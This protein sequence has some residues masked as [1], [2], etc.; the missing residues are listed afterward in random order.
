MHTVLG[1]E[2]YGELCKFTCEK[3]RQTGIDSN[4]E[5]LLLTSDDGI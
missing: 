5:L 3:L 1:Q 2:N 4:F